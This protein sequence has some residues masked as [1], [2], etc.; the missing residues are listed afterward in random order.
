MHKIILM[1]Q[2]IYIYDKMI[3]IGSGVQ[4]YYVET[5][6]EASLKVYNTTQ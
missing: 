3:Y 2:Y 1:I 6:I 5:K 4:K